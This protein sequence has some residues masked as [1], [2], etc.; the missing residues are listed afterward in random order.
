[1]PILRRTDKEGVRQNIDQHANDLRKKFR[2]YS[3]RVGQYRVLLREAE[4][5]LSSYHVEEIRYFMQEGVFAKPLR[6]ALRDYL[7]RRI[8]NGDLDNDRTARGDGDSC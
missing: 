1:M 5:L 3:I 8:T 4:S 2:D 7:F 6:G